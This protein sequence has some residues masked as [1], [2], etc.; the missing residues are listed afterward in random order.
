MKKLSLMTLAFLLAPFSAS[1]MTAQNYNDQPINGQPFNVVQRYEKGELH[2]KMRKHHTSFG[3][4]A[5][6]AYDTN[7]REMKLLVRC[8]REPKACSPR[9]VDPILQTADNFSK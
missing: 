2:A 6:V 3:N 4:F 1:A 8:Y 9:Q 5:Q 7:H